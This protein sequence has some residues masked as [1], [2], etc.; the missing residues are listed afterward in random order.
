MAVASIVCMATMEEGIHPK[1]TFVAEDCIGNEMEL[2]SCASSTSST[3]N[4]VKAMFIVCVRISARFWKNIC[5][6]STCRPRAAGCSSRPEEI[7]P[8]VEDALPRV[9][10]ASVNCHT[11]TPVLRSYWNTQHANWRPS[12]NLVASAAEHPP[13]CARLSAGHSTLHFTWIADTQPGG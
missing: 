3:S 2:T 9:H 10:L 13:E 4:R 12:A 6:I 8:E 5:K 11:D 1:A 7:F